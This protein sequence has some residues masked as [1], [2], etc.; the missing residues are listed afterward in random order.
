MV[1]SPYGT[2]LLGSESGRRSW[3]MAPLVPPSYYVENIIYSLDGKTLASENENDILILSVATGKP[4]GHR[5][6]PQLT[7]EPF[8]SLF[9]MGFSPDGKT[10]AAGSSDGNIFL[11]DITT[12]KPSAPP[13][14]DSSPVESVAF[15]P[16]G[17]TLAS[18]NDDG[19]IILW[20]LVTRKPIGQPLLGY[21]TGVPSG[22]TSLVFS[23]DGRTLGS[24]NGNGT[25]LLWDLTAGVRLGQPLNVNGGGTS[26]MVFSPD[27]RF[28]ASATYHNTLVL[29]N[30]DPEFWV[31]FA[32][33]RAGRNLTRSEW[34]Q[35]FP[36]ENYRATC[37][38]WPVELDI[39]TISKTG[40]VQSSHR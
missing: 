39:S 32:C 15:S 2:C 4:I 23:P 26:N 40:A 33:Q 7:K 14:T 24:G 5:L 16:D 34:A 28:L 8:P 29:W 25:I 37:P 30:L 13:F 11:W 10:L 27:G 6:I 18:G 36:G 9:S 35:Y 1:L 12:Q 21:I 31:T 17:R 20:N 19:T 3:W 38:Q 22:Q